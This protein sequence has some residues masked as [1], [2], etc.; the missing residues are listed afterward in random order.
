VKPSVDETQPRLSS[1]QL[2]AAALGWIA[3]ERECDIF[4]S[5]AAMSFEHEGL[6]FNLLDTPDHQDF[7]E[8]TYRSL[9]RSLTLPCS[10][11]N[12][13]IACLIVKILLS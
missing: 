4:V 11:G 1:L 12:R 3:I 8:A 10:R 9:M 7:S 13:W 2:S 5:S 6:A